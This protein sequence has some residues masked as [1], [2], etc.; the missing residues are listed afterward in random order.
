[1]SEDLTSEC[2]GC[3]CFV[4]YP[5]RLNP[6]GTENLC[7]FCFLGCTWSIRPFRSHVPPG[8]SDR[9]YH[10]GQFHTAEW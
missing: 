2:L 10:G 4:K 6:D 1:M 7:L 5:I 8:A 9:Q 3:G